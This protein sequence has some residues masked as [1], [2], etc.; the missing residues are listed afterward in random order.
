MYASQ[1]VYLNRNIFRYFTHFY[2]LG[3]I[4]SIGLLVLTTA[5]YT[6]LVQ[7]SPSLLTFIDHR[8]TIG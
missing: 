5:C 2:V 6:G 8:V 4:L 1:Y 7:L 3:S